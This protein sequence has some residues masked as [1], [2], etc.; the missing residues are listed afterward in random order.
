MFYLQKEALQKVPVRIWIEGIS[1]NTFT[2][3]WSVDG[4]YKDFQVNE[5][6]YTFS[7]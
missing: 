5:N 4:Q 6:L 2:Y 3:G 7:L 1:M